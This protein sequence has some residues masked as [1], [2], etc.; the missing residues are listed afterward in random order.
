MQNAQWDRPDLTSDENDNADI[1]WPKSPEEQVDRF[2]VRA[3]LLTL[4][5]ALFLAAVWVASAPSFGKCGALE[6]QSARLACYENLR[7]ELLKP[8][9]KG[10]DIR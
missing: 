9:A 1:R 6:D 4:C 5:I 10:A 3:A 7:S 2:G 8:P